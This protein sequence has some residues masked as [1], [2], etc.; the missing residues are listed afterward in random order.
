MGRGESGG[1]VWSTSLIW[2]GSKP[3]LLLLIIT[4]GP[5][6]RMPRSDKR[7]GVTLPSAPRTGGKVS[8]VTTAA[9]IPVSLVSR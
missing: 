1:G 9:G 7:I 8:G 6:T 4:P 2:P 5:A 3:L